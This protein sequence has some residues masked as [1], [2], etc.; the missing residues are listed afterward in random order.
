M[1]RKSLNLCKK[2]PSDQIS[3]I[4]LRSECRALLCPKCHADHKH[5]KKEDLSETLLTKYRFLSFLGKG[6]CGRVFCV[7]EELERFAVKVVD[8]FDGVNE[9]MTPQLKQMY[10]N[11]YL[12]EAE[13]HRAL[14]NQFIINYYDHYYVDSEEIIVIKME[15]ANGNLT[16]SLEDLKEEQAL[17]WFGQICAAVSYLHKKD[18]IHR[19]LKP[20][21]ILLKENRVK[22]C[23]FGGAKLMEQTR[24]SAYRKD[25][26]LFL[27]TQE[28]LAPEIFS[29]DLKKFTKATDI[30]AMGVILYKMVSQ[31]NHPLLYGVEDP[32]NLSRDEKIDKMT[33]NLE[34]LKENPT[35]VSKLLKNIYMGNIISRCLQVDPLKRIEITQLVGLVKDKLDDEGLD[36]LSVI[37]D[38]DQISKKKPEES[39]LTSKKKEGEDSNSLSLSKKKG[40]DE[41]EI[42]DEP[43]KFNQKGHGFFRTGDFEK[44][45]KE[46]DSALK[47]KPIAKYYMNKAT[48]LM[49]LN[50]LVEA[51]ENLDL[52][53]KFDPKYNKVHS[54]KGKIFLLQQDY[55][56]ANKAFREGLKL[57]PND[58]E[59]QNGVELISEEKEKEGNKL[60]ISAESLYS[61]GNYEKSLEEISKAIQFCPEKG[62]YHFLQAKNLVKLNNFKEALVSAK[63]CADLD[64]GVEIHMLIGDC[65]T[66]LDRFDE[67]IIFYGKA[68]Q[69]QPNNMNLKKIIEKTKE[70]LANQLYVKSETFFQK[71]EFPLALINITQALNLLP[72]NL[73]FIFLKAS[74]EDEQGDK[75]NALLTFTNY[76]CRDESNPEV[77]C[78]VGKIFLE[79]GQPQMALPI[80][81][82]G[83][84]ISP[85]HK[86]M[87]NCLSAINKLLGSKVTTKVSKDIKDIIAE[88]NRDEHEEN[89]ENC[90]EIQQSLNNYS[91][92]DKLV[93]RGL[94]IEFTRVLQ[95]YDPDQKKLK[96]FNTWVKTTKIR[97]P[98]VEIVYYGN[99][100]VGVQAIENIR[101]G[102]V[103]L[104]IPEENLISLESAIF[105]DFKARSN[106]KKIQWDGPKHTAFAAFLLENRSKKS[107]WS[108][109]F[110]MLPAKMH[111][112]PLFFS[113][114]ELTELKGTDFLSKIEKQKQLFKRDYLKLTSNMP[115][116]SNYSFEDFCS[117]RLI[118]SSRVFG[119]ENSNSQKTDALI[120]FADFVNPGNKNTV[121]A[122]EKSNACFEFKAM[123][124]IKKGE[125]IKITFGKKCNTRFLVNYGYI[126]E[127]NQNNN[128]VGLDVVL[129]E[130][131]VF[132]KERKKILKVDSDEKTIILVLRW[133]EDEFLELLQKIRILLA[134]N[135]SILIKIS[136]TEI[137]S[138]Q[139]E[140]NSLYFL[141]DILSKRLKE[142]P[143]TYEEDLKLLKKEDLTLNEMNCIKSRMGEKKL[144]ESHLEISKFLDLV[145]ETTQ[146][147]NS[148]DVELANLLY[149]ESISKHFKEN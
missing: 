34:K 134:E 142:Y 15:M 65:N 99:V 121:W 120:P 126:E 64:E 9:S 122:F 4:C 83:L 102:E 137:T 111:T 72:Q 13:I 107:I 70:D 84:S 81:Q 96:N 28:Y 14:R 90:N 22:I 2:H 140:K 20:G 31:G 77:F 128:E 35:L 38:K 131:D 108:P 79:M 8:V 46:Y 106:E 23:D 7:E 118:V 73:K 139:S 17:V 39:N 32:E 136:L 116:F 76:L 54:K 115:E 27:G 1:E 127:N 69:I 86:G 51:L 47:L 24:S 133:Q 56:N 58:E 100:G 16:N 91:E 92:N 147:L 109:Y 80:L 74:I 144:I 88:I 135:I 75:K 68:L 149:F 30:W 26:E 3:L 49:K 10:C 37:L 138:V 25:K 36:T 44:A 66:H 97:A 132:L 117:N 114:K 146:A 89:K 21:N 71:K 145:L 60:R 78:R 52:C 112:N 42:S 103:I 11:E 143:T 93:V 101:D 124:E 62:N 105:N 5:K 94:K 19:D 113:E 130:K 110:D 148:N 6:G 29:Q 50:R 63:K 119:Y 67:A 98:K 48:C 141:R 41:P 55:I 85:N 82:K 45:L 12:R 129:D 59:C 43:E 53:L 57:D 123:Q 33:E 87:Q 95:P 104:S 61:K 125:P 40:K 18:I